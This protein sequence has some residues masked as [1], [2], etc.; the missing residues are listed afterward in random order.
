MKTLFDNIYL[1][2]PH[3]AIHFVPFLT[4]TSVFLFALVRCQCWWVLSSFYPLGR[5]LIIGTG[6]RVQVFSLILDSSFGLSAGIRSAGDLVP[7]TLWDRILLQQRR[8]T[9]LFSIRKSLACTRALKLTTT[10]MYIARA[11]CECQ[12][13]VG[14]S[15]LNARWS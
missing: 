13:A 5:S 4:C 2:G 10:N 6:C 7:E 14:T 15:G 9:C 1:W 12:P 8:T 3:I 11:R